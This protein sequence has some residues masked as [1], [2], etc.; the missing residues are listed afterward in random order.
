MSPF[1]YF[2]EI[3]HINPDPAT[4]RR[5]EMEERFEKLGIA[6]RVRRFPAAPGA[7]TAFAHRRIIEMASAAACRSVLVLEDDVL[8]LAHSLEVL[9]GAVA[10]LQ[11]IEWSLCL[12]GG[13]RWAGE[14]EAVPG[15]R[16]LSL[17]HEVTGTHALAYS[18]RI[19]SRLLEDLPADPEDMAA[20]PERQQG[21]GQYLLGIDQAVLVRPP[22]ATLPY[23]LPYEEPADQFQFTV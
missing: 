2:D 7:D 9:A 20:W 19:F 5:Q 1:D 22:V 3:F 11:G 4:Q 14:P 13:F 23:M 18:G 10:E 15:C 21:L 6:R 12:L 17:A 16:H 8:F